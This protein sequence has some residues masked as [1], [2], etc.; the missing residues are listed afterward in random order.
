M[1]IFYTPPYFGGVVSFLC[2]H[3]A[4][5]IF[6]ETSQQFL[7]KYN[8]MVDSDNWDYKLFLL[9]NAIE[10]DLDNYE[11]RLERA[12]E[13]Y[14]AT[15]YRMALYD[16]LI[17]FDNDYKIELVNLYIALTMVELKHYKVALEHFKYSDIETSPMYFGAYGNCLIELGRNKKACFFLEKYIEEY[18]EEHGA[19]YDLAKALYNRKLYKKSLK[20]INKALELRGGC[21]YYYKE[22]KTSIGI[23]LEKRNCITSKTM[24][25]KAFE[26]N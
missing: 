11:A 1:N 7:E 3:K 9:T 21:G 25:I 12:I 6:M 4:K 13:N 24:K 15:N 8:E 14:I 20:M 22:L 23:E 16:L 26:L 5:Y 10:L 18:T 19:Y 17:C 2:T